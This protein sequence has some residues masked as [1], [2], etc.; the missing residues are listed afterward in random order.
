[1]FGLY[2][3]RYDSGCGCFKMAHIQIAV[4]ATPDGHKDFQQQVCEQRYKTK[5]TL[6]QGTYGPTISEVKYYD[7]R[8]RKEDVPAFLRQ[9][10]VITEHHH[11]M[12]VRDRFKKF[13]INKVMKLW[14]WI[15]RRIGWGFPKPDESVEK[16]HTR[17]W[18]Y[19]FGIGQI[20]DVPQKG[21]F[22]KEREVL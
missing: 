10:D 13:H 18:R 21:E 11:K 15:L 14:G 16:V 22:G 2:C 8:L 6:R 1:M 20:P 17:S 19:V 12:N 4:Y 5:G 9:F 3:L 7:I